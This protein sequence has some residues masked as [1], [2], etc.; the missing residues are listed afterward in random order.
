MSHAS[1]GAVSPLLQAAIAQSAA[2]ARRELI[3]GS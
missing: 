1:L 2:K 3:V